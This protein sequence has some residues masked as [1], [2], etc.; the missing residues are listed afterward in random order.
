MKSLHKIGCG[1][2]WLTIGG[3]Q[4]SPENISHQSAL[5]LPKRNVYKWQQC[6]PDRN[7]HGS[8]LLTATLFALQNKRRACTL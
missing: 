5:K 3:N 6:V 4:S 2:I 7:H 1:A 8:R